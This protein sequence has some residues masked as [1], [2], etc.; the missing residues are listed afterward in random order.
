M[1]LTQFWT[2]ELVP[3]PFI[4]LIKWKYIEICQFSKAYIYHL[5]FSIIHP[6][7][8]LKHWK[9]DIIGYWVFGAGC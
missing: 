6:F 8:K 5:Q 3:G 9:L 4:I 1:L 7:K 2:M